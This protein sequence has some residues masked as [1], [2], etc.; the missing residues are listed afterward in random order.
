MLSLEQAFGSAPSLAALQQRIRDSQRYLDWIH[1]ALPSSLR[2]QIKA[3]PVQEK[4]WCLLVSNASVSTKLRH[5]VPT[6]LTILSENGAQVNSIRIK[7]QVSE[8]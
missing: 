3:G 6:L 2:K 1:P 4:E 5:L 7:V 8:R